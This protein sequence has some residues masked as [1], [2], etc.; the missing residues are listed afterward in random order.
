MPVNTSDQWTARNPTIAAGEIGYETD[1]GRFKVSDGVTAWNNLA[2]ADDEIAASSAVASQYERVQLIEDQTRETNG[3]FSF[4]DIPAGWTDL[5][6]S[7]EGVGAT[8]TPNILLRFNGDSGENYSHVRMSQ[9][10]TSPAPAGFAALTADRVEL[11]GF[12]NEGGAIRIIVPHYRST[13]HKRV[14]FH[15]VGAGSDLVS[16]TSGSGVWRN[17]NPITS[18]QVVCNVAGGFLAGARAVL[19]GVGPT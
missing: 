18:L 10:T 17:T 1:T 9:N 11:G 13:R 14:Q 5:I 2:Y 4:T 3:N 7:V 8:A 15:T 12:R 16:S 6:V 19:L